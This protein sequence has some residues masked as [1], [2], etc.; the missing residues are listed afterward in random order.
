MKKKKSEDS[1]IREAEVFGLNHKFAVNAEECDISKG[2]C[3]AGS[4]WNG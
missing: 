2:G 3:L 1:K 4:R